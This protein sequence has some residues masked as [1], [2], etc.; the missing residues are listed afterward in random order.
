MKDKLDSINLLILRELRE[1]SR[2]SIRELSN[3]LK[4]HP[5]TLM[6]RIKKLERDGLIRKYVAEIDYAKLDYGVHA[7][8]SMKVN[9]DAKSDWKILDEL[10]A[11]KD[12]VS[13][14]AATG[15]YDVVAIVR[16]KS[17]ASLT[18]LIAEL[19][20]KP[21]IVETNT[22]FLLYPFKHAYEFNPL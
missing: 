11:F 3:K 22:L 20:K 1:N 9:K 18:V 13:L 7:L 8:I 21:Y 6:Q 16:T 12:I 5:N 4:I 15:A 2:R 10:R 14:Y 19:N 17:S